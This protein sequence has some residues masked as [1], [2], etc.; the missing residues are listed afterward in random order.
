M[1]VVVAMDS[2]KGCLSSREAGEAVRLGFL[3]RE[4]DADVT[5]LPMAD[6][7][8][9]TASVLRDYL[10]GS[11]KECKSVDALGRPVVSGFVWI[12]DKR[13]AIV[14]LASACG[15]A[16]LKLSERNVMRTS[17]YGF[18]LLIMEALKLQP[19]TVL[20][21]L[22]GSATNDAAL[23]A[24]Q[25]LGL[26]IRLKS[27]GDCFRPV[28]G[29]DLQDIWTFDNSSL[30]EL[31]DRYNFQYLYDAKIPFV[32]PTGAVRLYSAQKGATLS[33]MDQLEDGMAN[34]AA[35][36]SQTTGVNPSEVPG[37]GAA[38]GCGGSL[39]TFLNATPLAGADYILDA[40]GFDDIV[41]DADWL[42]TGEG[43]VDAQTL[44]GK[45][46]ATLVRRARQVNPEV[47]VA[48]LA[49]SI[50]EDFTSAPQDVQYVIDINKPLAPDFS[51]AAV[52]LRNAARELPFT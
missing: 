9:G 17:T 34:I 30:E 28:A 3:D 27:T 35:L 46:P 43:R 32:G 1:K 25:S 31:T 11:W 8:E 51:K 50:A 26:R 29:A 49:G 33:E 15:L 13:L 24:L 2:F 21:T 42:I 20:L 6:G 39:A 16:M 48:I 45:A 5:V 36:I 14:E 52:R 18:G 37:A 44:Q 4:P 19:A 41:R 7:G 40:A 12:A 10:G 38:G 23:G 47:R 22:G